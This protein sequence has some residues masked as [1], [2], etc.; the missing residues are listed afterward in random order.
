MLN[1]YIPYSF[2]HCFKILKLNSCA[3]FIFPIQ[4]VSKYE[5]YVMG[6]K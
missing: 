3:F 5:M 6:K 4:L 1:M 2:Y